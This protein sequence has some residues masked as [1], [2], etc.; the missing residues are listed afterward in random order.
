[1]NQHLPRILRWLDVSKAGES[2]VRVLAICAKDVGLACL[3]FLL[4]EFPD[5]DYDFVVGEPGGD[6]IV[7]E[8]EKA[9]RPWRRLSDAVLADIAGGRSGEYDWLLNLW[10]AAILRAN[11][12]ARARNSLNIHPS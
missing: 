4:E 10:G 1:M 12:L 2:R 9:G 6:E 11:Q 7:G 5:D 8:L 3:R